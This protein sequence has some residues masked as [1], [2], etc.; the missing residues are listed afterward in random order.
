MIISNE[1]N[2]SELEI[3]VVLGASNKLNNGNIVAF[4]T[5]TVYGLGVDAENET[6]VSRM[7]E[8]KGRP[9]NHPVIVHIASISDVSYWAKEIPK[10]ADELMKKFWPGPMTLIL[11]RSEK[12]KNFITGGQDFV[13]LRLPLNPTA[14]SLLQAFAKLGGHGVAAP[15]ANR[16]GSI[17]PTS[18]NDVRE[19]IGAY[20]G[21]D[22]LILDGGASEIGVES[23]IIDC[24]RALPRIL[25]L[26]AITEAMIREISPID[27]DNDL[28]EIRVSGSLTRH[29]SPKAKV[30]TD[31]AASAGEGLIALSS[32]LTPQG[33]IRLAEPKNDTEYAR[34][35]YSALRDGDS[36]G[37]TTIVAVPPAG[38]GLAA[39]IR[40]RISRASA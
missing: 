30:I 27:L 5:E 4:P 28:N 21:S 40:D 37:L 31:R 6:A 24:S 29:Y 11:P 25:R 35:L 12:A 26:G 18:A 1:H 17:S 14:L 36:R 15:S 34:L 3:G 13:G 2:N 10:Y 8:I 39:A 9:K 23:T 33:A 19:E 32:V 7:Y 22:D 38:D 16:F 20:L